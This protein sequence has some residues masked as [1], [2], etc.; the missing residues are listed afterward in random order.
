MKLIK[1]VGDFLIDAPVVVAAIASVLVYNTL[2]LPPFTGPQ[3]YLIVPLVSAIFI[4]MVV[5]GYAM[6][7][8]TEL[9]KSG[10]IK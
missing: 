5:Y 3:W 2:S 8:Q 10:K 4:G 1:L 9:K 6:K 7:I